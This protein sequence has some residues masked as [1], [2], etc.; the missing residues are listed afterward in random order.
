MKKCT[1]SGNDIIFKL[2]VCLSNDSVNAFFFVTANK[3]KVLIR[4]SADFLPVI[5]GKNVLLPAHTR[6]TIISARWNAAM[7]LPW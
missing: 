3:T 6:A 2:N 7:S 4:K 1:K 5:V